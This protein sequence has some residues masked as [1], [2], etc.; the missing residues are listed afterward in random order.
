MKC[1]RDSFLHA[2]LE[3]KILA[4]VIAREFALDEVDAWKKFVRLKE[5]PKFF[6]DFADRAAEAAEDFV[7][8]ILVEREERERKSRAAKSSPI[9]TGTR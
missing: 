5:V 4:V 8:D 7:E 3:E 1:T 9:A 2:S 6:S